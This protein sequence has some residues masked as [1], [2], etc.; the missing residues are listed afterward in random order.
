ME[1]NDA[2][3]PWDTNRNLFLFHNGYHT[4]PYDFVSGDAYSDGS[5]FDTL[6]SDGSEDFWQNSDYR[7]CEEITIAAKRITPDG[8]EDEYQ[9]LTNTWFLD[10]VT[11]SCTA[12]GCT[13]V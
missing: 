6:L 12:S 1:I 5:D 3:S 8:V 4:L 9:I 11:C 2:V 7:S 10:T 13:Q